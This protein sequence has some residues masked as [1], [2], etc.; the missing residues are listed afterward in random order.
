RFAREAAYSQWFGLYRRD[1]DS[2]AAAARQLAK[3]H[4]PASRPA[5][6]ASPEG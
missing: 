2:G 5:S 4:R 3:V 1:Q 6:E